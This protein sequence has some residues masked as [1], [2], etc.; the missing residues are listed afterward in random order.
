MLVGQLIGECVYFGLSNAETNGT[1]PIMVLPIN[2]Q[3][4]QSSLYTEYD[5]A[6]RVDLGSGVMGY[7]VAG[8]SSV[9]IG[10]SE[11][12]SP[13]ANANKWYCPAKVIANAGAATTNTGK[14]SCPAMTAVM[15]QLAA[16]S[17]ANGGNVEPTVTQVQ[18]GGHQPPG[19]T[20][21][22][23]SSSDDD[24]NTAV[25]IIIIA[26]VVLLCC[27]LAAIG[28]RQKDK[29]KAEAAGGGGNRPLTDAER[30]ELAASGGPGAKE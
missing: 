17:K 27:I 29:Q 16:V 18:A 23:S 5:F 7:R 13:V 28:K 6:E 25:I 12:S 1:G 30:K 8:L 4:G 19:W 10:N 24:D 26:A 14:Y 22:T 3:I 21:A 11:I 9:T 20:P 15:V 2:T